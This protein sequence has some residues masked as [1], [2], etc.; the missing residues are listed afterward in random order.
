MH[1]T[2]RSCS[3]RRATATLTVMFVVMMSIPLWADVVKLRRLMT[4]ETGDFVVFFSVLDSNRD[5]VSDPAEIPLS[6][7]KLEAGD[8]L[9]ELEQLELDSATIE[10]LQSYQVPFRVFVLIPDTDLFNGSEVDAVWPD[11]SGLRSSLTE[12]MQML[13]ERSDIRLHV[14]VYNRDVTWLPEYNT[15][16]V[17]E[18]RATLLSADYAEPPTTLDSRVEDP[19]GAIDSTYRNRLRR[20]SRPPGG[21]DFVYFFIMVTSSQAQVDITQEFNESIEEFRQVFDNNDM[22]D[23]I[24]M[25]LVYD[26]FASD[27]IYVS[28][29]EHLRFAQG[30]TPDRGTY[31]LAGN[32]DQ[33]ERALSQMFDE[34][35]SS[36]ILRFNNSGLEG[37]RNYYF[38]LKVTPQGGEE[39]ESNSMLA[40]VN[41]RDTNYVKWIIIGGAILFGLLLFLILLVWIVRRPKKEKKEENVEAVPVEQPEQCVQCGRLLRKDIQ[42]CPHC[43]AEPNHGLLRA[44]EG[45]DSGWTFF[46]R[47]NITELGRGVALYQNQIVVKEDPGVSKKHLKISVQEGQRYLVED[48]SSQGTFIDGKRVQQQFLRNGDVIA[49]GTSTKLKFTIS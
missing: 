31:R 21:D 12:A 4:D 39:T 23:V 32:P 44:L 46:I 1:R 29:G 25:I 8:Q 48:N 28:G 49:I 34:I 45:P 36:F 22:A 38:R 37:D 47:Q 13:P 19:F 30:L 35:G 43:A 16:Q 33:A 26:P 14:G 27:D 24:P 6:G 15:T 40:H 11:E 42:Y 17:D 5:P 41:A 10:T 7:I 9:A 20:Q 18:L 2:R 3:L